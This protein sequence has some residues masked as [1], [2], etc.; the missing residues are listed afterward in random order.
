M[1][2]ILRHRQLDNILEKKVQEIEEKVNEETKSIYFCGYD[3][4]IY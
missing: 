1:L 2:S 4:N 3:Y